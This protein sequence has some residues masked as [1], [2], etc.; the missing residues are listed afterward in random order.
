MEKKLKKLSTPEIQ[1]IC[2]KMDIDCKNHKQILIHNL[3]KPL[4]D[5]YHNVIVELQEDTWNL[6]VRDIN[7]KKYFVRN[8]LTSHQKKVYDK[9]YKFLKRYKIKSVKRIDL[10]DG[11]KKTLIFS[12]IPVVF[13]IYKSNSVYQTE[14]K[15]YYDIKKL[16]LDKYFV[17]QYD[18]DDDS[19]TALADKLDSNRPKYL[20]SRQKIINA[21]QS[22]GVTI[23]DL[24][25]GD[26]IGH[27]NGRDVIFDV[28]SLKI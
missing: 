7:A 24:N 2:K 5:V 23:T 15:A 18:F 11:A 8:D 22:K 25:R 10:Q 13:K 3:L 1:R 27:Y 19:W 9:L 21:L 28:K 14:K 6:F 12:K 26:N 16:N 17:K 4:T 20:N